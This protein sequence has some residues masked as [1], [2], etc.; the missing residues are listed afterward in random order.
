MTDDNH[1]LV[2]L[3]DFLGAGGQEV[4]GYTTSNQVH[5]DEDNL[6]CEGGFTF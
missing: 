3:G 6:L 5:D 1:P 4:D 2:Y